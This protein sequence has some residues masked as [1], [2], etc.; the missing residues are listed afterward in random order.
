MEIIKEFNEK[1][2]FWTIK[3]EK[4]HRITSYREE[5]GILTYNSFEIA[6][7]PADTNLDCFYCVTAKEDAE[8]RARQEEAIKEAEE[9]RKE[10]E[11]HR[12]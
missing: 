2:N 12:A 1:Y 10:A 3:C 8:L 4:G 5:D 9:K 7:C 6:Y 11:A